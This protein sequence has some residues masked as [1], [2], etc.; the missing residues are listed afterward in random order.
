[1]RPWACRW[2]R[3]WAWHAETKEKRQFVIS[4][5]AIR[6]INVYA[7][8][9]FTQSV[10]FISVNL[11]FL[12]QCTESANED[13]KNANFVTFG[14]QNH[15]VFQCE[16]WLYVCLECLHP[17]KGKVYFLYFFSKENNCL[18]KIL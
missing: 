14:H 17:M 7:R 15:N 18:S 4:I 11:E 16:I 6:K 9:I 5:F 1:M 2:P 8:R 10:F 13:L 12:V 3:S